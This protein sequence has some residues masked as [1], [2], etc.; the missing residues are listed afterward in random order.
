MYGKTPPNKGI[1]GVVTFTQKQITCPH[2]NK[3]GGAT[4]MKR[5]HLD[6]C[7]FIKTKEINVI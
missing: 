3:I 1:T 6:N 5:W 7:K 4:M 2:C